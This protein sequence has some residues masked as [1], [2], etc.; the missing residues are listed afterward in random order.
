MD[1]TNASLQV[2]S[3]KLLKTADRLVK[4][5]TDCVKSSN[6]SMGNFKALLSCILIA[7]SLEAKLWENSP[8]LSKQLRNIDDRSA[9]LLCENG[10]R[11]IASILN[12]NSADVERVSSCVWHF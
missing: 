7:R 4:C 3:M 2:E 10:M 11:S 5:L 8:Y 12:A 1:I 9:R 6:S